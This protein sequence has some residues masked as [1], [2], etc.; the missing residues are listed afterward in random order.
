[1]IQNDAEKTGITGSPSKRQNTDVLTAS[2]ALQKSHVDIAA[3]IDEQSLERRK[4]QMLAKHAPIGMVLI[5]GEDNFEYINPKFIELFGWDPEE[6]PCGKVWLRKAFPDPAYRHEAIR[7]W[8]ED[9]T[10]MGLGEKSPRSFRVLCKD[11]SEKV[12]RFILTKLDN[13]KSLLTCEDITDRRRAAEDLRSA[14][15]KLLDIIEFLPDATFVIDKDKKVIAWNRAIEEMTGISKQDML[16]KGDYAYSIPFFGK[17]RPI[18]IDL[19]MLHDEEIECSYRYMERK[20]DTLYAETNPLNLASGEGVILWAKA[21]PIY[22][23]HGNVAG[24]IESIRDITD[25]KRSEEVADAANEKLQALIRASPLAIVTF[26]TH[27]IVLSWNKAA[28]RIFGWEEGEMLGK[29]PAF[30]AKDKMHEL[31]SLI[32]TVLQGKA[33]TGV[34]LKRLRKDGQTIEISLSSAPIRDAKGRIVGIISVMDDITQKKASERSLRESFHF[35]QMLIDTIPSPILYK[36]TDGR[37]LGCN[38]AFE[39]FVGHDLERIIGKTV[40]DL[41]PKEQ[42]DLCS[43]SDLALFKSPGIKIEEITMNLGQGRSL[44]VISNKAT[45]TNERGEIAGNVEVLIDISDRKASE[46]VL[47]AAKEAAEV[48]ARVKADFLANMSHE[49]RTPLNAVIGMTGL[50]LDAGLSAENRDYVETIRSSGDTL[51]ALINDILDFSKIDGGKMELESQPFDLA[52]CIEESLDYV[53]GMAAE[54]G[55]NLAYLIDE[56]APKTILGDLTRLRQILVNLLSN[57][58]KFTEKGE[59]LVTVADRRLADEYHEIRFTVR[60]TGIG[61]SREQIK[62]LFLSFSQ[63]DASTSRKYGGTGLGLAISKRLV[64]MMGGRIWVKSQPEKGSEFLFTIVAEAKSCDPKPHQDKDQPVLAEK[65]LL[66]MDSNPTSLQILETM[67]CNWGMHSFIVHDAM[68]ALNLMRSEIF[69]AVILASGDGKTDLGALAKEI[70]EYRRTL[71]IIAY[72][73]IGQRS[74]DAGQFAALLNKPIKPALLHKALLEIF[75]EKEICEL[76]P[77][78]PEKDLDNPLRILLAEDNVVNQKVALKMLKKLGYRA[79]LA[80]NGIEVLQS[81]ERQPYDVVLMDVQMPEMDGLEATRH[82]R[83]IWPN[84]G[85]KII[86][87]T[88]YAMQGDRE[89]CLNAGMNDYISKPMCINELA[90]SLRKWQPRSN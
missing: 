72:A 36:N 30:V 25:R 23:N 38:K 50:L 56:R 58:V 46:E 42:A 76:S 67:S 87:I 33:F 31:Y 52:G 55:L 71:P 84:D 32:D 18:L 1:M 37:F 9:S 7:L 65:R 41:Y 15:Q 66:I 61:I 74:D 57:A 34:E 51:L 53:A 20:G 59:V 89:R 3:T 4:F 28:K 22:D 24:A 14:N 8:I 6:L 5:D 75:G 70:R 54:K 17:A 69:D 79:D 21:S 73:S 85:P 82:I 26:D 10:M 62:R 48:A 63:I 11:G 43:A 49:I 44:D 64:E 80:A 40:Y 81:L 35:L 29:L 2:D 77:T 83:Q 39:M 88:A 27:G 12:I 19:I 78:L 90:R 60:D 47:R 45:Y 68:A 13:Q 86:A 16:G